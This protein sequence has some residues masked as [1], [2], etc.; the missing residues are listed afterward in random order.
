M[1]DHHDTVECMT[2]QSIDQFD[3]YKLYFSSFACE[4]VSVGRLMSCVYTSVQSVQFLLI[5]WPLLPHQEACVTDPGA[6]F[7]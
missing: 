2:D 7:M 5:N 1:I 6:P 3:I 4:T